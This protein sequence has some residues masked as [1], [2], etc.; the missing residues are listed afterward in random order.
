MPWNASLHTH[1][2][3][4]MRCDLLDQLTSF[5]LAAGVFDTSS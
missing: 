3:E 5:A 2:A 1:P 4:T